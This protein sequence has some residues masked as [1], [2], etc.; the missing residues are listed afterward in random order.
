MTA[1]CGVAG[2]VAQEKAG[3]LEPLASA[4][5]QWGKL[6]SCHLPLH[7]CTVAPNDGPT[8]LESAA[9]QQLT[10]PRCEPTTGKRFISQTSQ[11]KGAACHCGQVSAGPHFSCSAAAQEL[12]PAL[13]YPKHTLPAELSSLKA[14]LERQADGAFRTR[15]T[16]PHS[17]QKHTGTRAPTKPE[18]SPHCLPHCR[19]PFQD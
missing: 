15:C 9:Q 12:V 1:G 18:V 17:G 14:W 10:A 5:V 4:D 11:F 16:A 8:T 6:T 13:R 19:L 2:W 3:S 7:L